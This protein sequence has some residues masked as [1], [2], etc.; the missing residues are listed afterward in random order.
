MSKLRSAGKEQKVLDEVFGALVA[1][2]KRG[3]QEKRVNRGSR[4]QL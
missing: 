4:G 2:L 3:L 1:L